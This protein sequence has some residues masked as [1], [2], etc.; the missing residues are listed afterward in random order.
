M[1]Q[2]A[3]LILT[4]LMTVQIAVAAPVATAFE[5]IKKA[6][7]TELKT[8]DA[9]IP[10]E[11]I[12][13]T[14]MKEVYMVTLKGGQTLYTSAD[15]KHII[16]GDMLELD[17]GKVTNLTESIRSKQAADVLSKL[18]PKNM[19]V[20]S[21]KEKVKGVVYAFTD[22]DC[23]YCRKLHQ[24]VS[25]LNQL[26]IELRYLAFPRGGQQSPVFDKMVNAWC[27]TDRKQALTDLKNGKQVTD[28][29]DADKAACVAL[30]EEQYQVGIKLGVNGTPALFLENGQS[31]PG[32]RSASDIGAILGIGKKPVGHP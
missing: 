24:E 29:K 11:N 3:T 8:L 31:I 2:I 20:F 13:I 4:M 9:N 25:E 27:S 16:R 19:I 15:G 7:E 6:I 10:I 28:S 14:P 17:N 12:E 5:N 26:G 23:G 30:I 1:R 21:P 18:D 22:V 32:Y